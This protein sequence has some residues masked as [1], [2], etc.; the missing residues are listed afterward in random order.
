LLLA[1]LVYGFASQGDYSAEASAK[2]ALI[3]QNADPWKEDN[4]QY[5]R[6]ILAILKELS[7]KALA[8]ES[9]TDLVVWPE[10]AFV[11]RIFWHVNYRDNAESYAIVKD[12]MDFL[13]VEKTPYLLGNDDG[14]QELNAS[15][16]WERVDYN[17]ALL[18]EKDQLKQVYR[19]LHLVPFTEYFPFKETFP[20][21]YAMLLKAD[22]HFWKPGTEETVFTSGKLRF[23]TPICF[24]DSFG[25]LSRNFTRR[26]ANLL[27]N[28]SNDA[29]SGSLSSQMQHLSMAVFRA[30]ENRRSLVR[31]TASGQTCAVDPNGKIL[32]MARPFTAAFLN[33]EVPLV[34]GQTL[35]TRWGDLWGIL[36]SVLA[37][38]ALLL[39]AIRG[40]MGTIKTRRGL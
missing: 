35:Y 27:V 37:A 23:S 32:A 15:G 17:G 28:I 7:R 31:S 13:A 21:I 40:I 25:Y 22:T 12:L 14:R 33:V 34:K 5:H 11:P 4:P 19:K 39:G 3:Q 29:W 36:F 20:G 38:I 6:R 9:G 30:V 26:G 8:A 2:I 10:T 16:F 18:F 24:E 1:V